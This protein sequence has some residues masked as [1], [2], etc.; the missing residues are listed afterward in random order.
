MKSRLFFTSILILIFSITGFSQNAKQEQKATLIRQADFMVE[1]PSIAYQMA[2]GTFKPAVDEKKEYNPKRRDANKA[3]P[4]KGFPKGDDPL[5]KKQ[6][7]S[8]KIKGKEPILTFQ[9]ASSGSTP[10]DPTGAVGPNHFVN[11]WNSSFRIWD[12]DGNPLTP[13]ASLGTIFPGETAGDPIVMYDPFADRFVVTE[14]T[15]MNGF[16]VAVS[17][18]PDPVNSG[19]YTYY[20]STN[21][22]PDYP[23]FSL[24]SDGYYITSN[25]NSWSAGSSEVVYAI[26][27]DKMLNGDTDAEMIGFPLPTISTNGFYSPLGFNVTG[28]E[29][30]PPGNAPIVYMQDDS[31]SGVS[32]DHLKIWKIN[33]DWDT[34][35]NSTISNPEILNTQPFDGLFDGGSFSNLP[36]PSGPDL[37]ALQATIMYMA[38]Y[39]RFPDH[40]SVVFNFVVD[41]D[42]SDNLAGIRWYELRQD[43]DGDDWQIYQEGT[44]SQPDGHSAFSGNMC[45]D[46][47]G[48]IALA[49][50][51]VSNSQFPSLRYTGRY[52]ADPLNVMTIAEESYAE[53]T[54]SDPSTRYGDYSQMTIDP[55][56]DITFWSIGEYFTGGPR[57][58]QVGVFQI[59]ADLA[60]DVG[61]TS[62]D[63]PQNG[64][65]G[66]S[67]PITVT[68]RNFGIDTQSNIPVY[69]QIDDGIVV[70]ETYTGSITSNTNAQFTFTATGD[71]SETGA[72]YHVIAGTNLNSDQNLSNDTI[73]VMITH[74]YADDIGVTEISSPVSGPY[75]SSEEAVSATIENFGVNAQSDFNVSYILDNNP[76]VTEQVDGPLDAGAT[77]FYTFAQ[78]ADLSVIGNHTLVVTTALPSDPNNENDF[79]L[80]TI[81]NTLCQPELLCTQGVGF[82]EFHLGD[83]NNVSG[84]DPNGYGNYTNLSTELEQGSVNNLTVTTEYGSVFVKVWIDFNDNFLFE[85][86]EIVVNDYEIAPGQNGGNYTEIMPLT[87]PANAALGEHLMR[88]KTNY[89]EGV[90]SDPC[91]ATI[92]GETEDYTVSI[93]LGTGIGMQ[94]NESNK[95]ILAQ[96]VENHFTAIYHANNLKE[97]LILTIHNMQGQTVI[98]NR[99]ENVNGS[100]TFDFD[101]S[102]AQP[103]IYLL[104]LGSDD[105]GKVKRFIVK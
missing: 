26:E 39:R 38:Q 86:D 69:F 46:G 19:W 98:R 93:V 45:M 22:F 77:M 103:G 72:T 88:A 64:I 55:V 7:K 25:K 29:M 34:P 37:D 83:I 52:A 3:V 102:F 48:N 17:Q 24:W 32:T 27:R 47:Q 49:Y 41:L 2:N 40:N 78:T 56:D 104:R 70:S 65:L 4:G 96:S 21:S 101:M 28:S 84:C 20:F 36:Q 15:F 90:P 51:T 68:I 6:S 23:K 91:E 60:S 16:L 14:F 31:W 92:F 1:V 76:I 11:A 8:G 57:K 42:G 100:Y 61:I 30:P 9:A 35:S 87:I 33:V 97:T 73:S 82:Y 54:T 12:K 71:F 63:T 94:S 79:T 81:A 89:N 99:V 74:L 67:E 43:N 59:A 80:D 85:T 50:T 10:T 13:A 18:G 105:F 53:G 62:I 44:Y 95:L 66:D 75:L 5:W 58:N